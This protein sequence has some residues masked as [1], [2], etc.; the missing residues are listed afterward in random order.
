MKCQMDYMESIKQLE[1]K[2]VNNQQNHGNNGFVNGTYDGEVFWFWNY[3]Y[4]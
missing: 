2:W 3:I 4:I 1:E